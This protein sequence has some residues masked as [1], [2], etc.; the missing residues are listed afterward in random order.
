MKNILERN[1]ENGTA[2]KIAT[3]KAK[4]KESYEFKRKYA[5]IRAWEFYDHPEIARNCYVDVG[6]LYGND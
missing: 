5:E 1:E 4:Q 2:L 3:F 6:G